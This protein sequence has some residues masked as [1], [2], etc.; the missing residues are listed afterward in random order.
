MKKVGKFLFF[1]T[2]L[3]FVGCKSST[4]TKGTTSSTV[5]TSEQS[6]IKNISGY[7]ID[8]PVV[9][10]N[11]EIYDENNSLLFSE[12]N[13]TDVN[14]KFSVEINQTKSKYYLLKSNHGYIKNKY[15]EYELASVVFND[16]KKEVY[17]N[18]FSTLILKILKLKN[19]AITK[20][21]VDYAQKLIKNELG[22]NDLS[23]IS[24]DFSNF[25]QKKWN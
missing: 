6:I 15:F 7:V 24:S 10:A 17:I 23:T 12:E 1:L 4:E 11:I 18:P 21:N 20:E 22:I 5:V 16:D 13:A 2:V 3:F 9:W 8:D 14:G 19:K 25:L